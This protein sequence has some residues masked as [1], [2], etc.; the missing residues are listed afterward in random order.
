[1]S[2]PLGKGKELT[3]LMKRMTLK[4]NGDKHYLLDAFKVMLWLYFP[5]LFQM[6][7]ISGKKKGSG[8]DAHS[9]VV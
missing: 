8:F 9:P 1:M 2:H 4:L 6:V 3:P 5:F 7:D